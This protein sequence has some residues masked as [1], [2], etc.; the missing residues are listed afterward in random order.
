MAR[1]HMP[2]KVLAGRFLLPALALCGLALMASPAAASCEGISNAFAYNECLAKQAPARSQRAPRV[3]AGDPEE[4]VINRR[5]RG[6]RRTLFGPD[7][8]AMSGVELTRRNG[9]TSAVIDPWNGVR[10]ATRGKRRR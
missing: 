5:G 1:S 2:P 9:R 4:S 3:T 6:P 8:S 10:P 7:S